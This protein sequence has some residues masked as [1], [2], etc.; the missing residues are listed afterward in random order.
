MEVTKVITNCLSSKFI[1]IDINKVC[2]WRIWWRHFC[3]IIWIIL[4]EIIC[5]IYFKFTST[6]L[7]SYN[8]TR[9]KRCSIGSII[10]RWIFNDFNNFRNQII[11]NFLSIKETKEVSSWFH[12]EYRNFY[13]SRTNPWNYCAWNK[14]ISNRSTINPWHNSCANSSSYL[15]SSCCNPCNSI[16]STTS[17]PVRTTTRSNRSSATSYDTSPCCLPWVP[18]YRCKT[19]LISS[20]A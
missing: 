10:N 1:C 19:I 17:T 4:I 12:S 6:C 11:I 2:S 5:R 13:V 14:P 18:L 8:F 16:Y 7:T 3:I 20:K 9:Y 15:S